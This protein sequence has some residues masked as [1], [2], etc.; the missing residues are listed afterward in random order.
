MRLAAKL[1]LAFL[2][3]A[4]ILL[5]IDGLFAAR[6]ERFMFEQNAAADARLLGRA[7]QTVVEGA[8]SLDGEAAALRLVEAVGRQQSPFAIRWLWLDTD[9]AGLATPLAAD[10]LRRLGEG[11]EVVL[12]HHTGSESFL[13]TYFPLRPDGV[14]LGALELTESLAP[15][16][17]AARSTAVRIG[18][19]TL[20]LSVLAVLLAVP[21]GLFV[22]GRPLR[23][24]VDKTRRIGREDFSEP[25][26]LAGRDEL[27][28]LAESLNAMSE[29]LKSSRD[30][31]REE[32]DA[33]IAALEQLRH[34]DRLRTVGRLASGVAHELG[35]PLNV[36]QGRADL[37]A[38]RRFS[39]DETVKAAE[40]IKAQ[41]ESMT[42]IIRRLLDFAR[43]RSPNKIDCRPDQIAREV[44][45]LLGSMA[46]KKGAVL[47]VNESERVGEIRADPIQIRQVLTNL[48]INALQ[49]VGSQGTVEIGLALEDATPP[50]GVNAKPGLYLC[51]SVEDNGSGIA[52]D[53]LS[54]IFE[55][56]FTTKDVGE[57]TGLGLSI[58]H[59]IAREHGG[60]TSVT[61]TPGRGSRLA[62]YLP[63]EED[64]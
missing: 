10:D 47:R 45:D 7:L 53:D 56:F 49:A 13:V 54:Q 44:V 28:E 51:I 23:T 48:V 34:E 40:T 8:W 33:R 55:P 9:S 24:L 26:Q 1:V 61:S 31:L 43:R 38:R 15:V 60:W 14:R 46:R 27:T 36:V 57:G 6:R 50:E 62:V 18:L 29:R 16:E 4:V 64:A 32:T 17:G 20:G 39:A 11:Q 25:L 22:V 41:A 3:G 59:G 63:V 2:A 19:L 52:E 30:R 21:Y 35:T 37:I 58:V 12:R 5:V 42:G